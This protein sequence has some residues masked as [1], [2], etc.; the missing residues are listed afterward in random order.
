MNLLIGLGREFLVFYGIHVL[1]VNEE[2]IDQRDKRFNRFPIGTQRGFNRRVDA[3]FAAGLQKCAREF[4]LIQG[5][6]ARQGHTAAGPTV[7]RLVLHDRF[8]NLADG[9]V[10]ADRLFGSVLEHRLDFPVLGFGI[11]APAAAQDTAF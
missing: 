10:I 6:A 3:V 9:C 4:R 5:F 1:D 11:A 7:I 2:R 8:Q